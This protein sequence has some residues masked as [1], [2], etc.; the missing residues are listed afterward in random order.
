MFHDVSPVLVLRMTMPRGSARA[1]QSS[2]I[3][4]DSRW[5]D[6]L[7]TENWSRGQN[8]LTS[9]AG[10]SLSTWCLLVVFL[11]VLITQSLWVYDIYSKHRFVGFDVFRNISNDI[12][13]TNCKDLVTWILGHGW[14]YSSQNHGP[15]LSGFNLF[16]LQVPWYL[17]L[18]TNERGNTCQ[19][20]WAKQCQCVMKMLR[21]LLLE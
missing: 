16:A 10:S 21:Y 17:D 9:T 2:V 8:P 4:I 15:Q 12:T 14:A 1:L 7:C 20:R 19:T 3:R 11:I 18:H 13:T 6:P 5:D